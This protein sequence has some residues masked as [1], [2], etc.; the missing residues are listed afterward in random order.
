MKINSYRTAP[1]LASI[2][3]P[4]YAET[5]Q[6]GS[7]Q[8]IESRYHERNIRRTNKRIY[9]AE[10]RCTGFASRSR[11]ESELLGKST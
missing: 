5:Q 7:F 4:V 1:S 8:S 6:F 11:I 2:I 9:P 3:P 10:W